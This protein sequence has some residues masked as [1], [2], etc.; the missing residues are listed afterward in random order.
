MKWPAEFLTRMQSYFGNDYDTFLEGLSKPAPVSIRMNERKAIRQFENC[1]SIPW[2]RSGFYLEER[3][4]FTLDPLFHAGCY[5]VQEAGSQFLEQLF[6]HAIKEKEEPIVLDLCAAP[7]GKSTHL[8][9]LMNGS[10]LLV[11]NE[12]ISSRNK[13]LQQNIAKWGFANSIVT[14]ND[15]SDFGKAGEL[16][17]VIVVDAPC[18]G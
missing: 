5:Y 12:V 18:S 7:G 14:Q 15:S 6:L 16:F 10:G 4:S 3:P 11:S 8:L 9:S 2:S 13:V 17:D 1:K